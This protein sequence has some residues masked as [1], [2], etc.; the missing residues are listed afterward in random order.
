MRKNKVQYIVLSCIALSLLLLT[1]PKIGAQEKKVFLADKII[2]VVGDQMILFSDF[3]MSQEYYK[4]ENRIPSS[5]VLSEDEKT[6][7]LSQMLLVKLMATQ[8]RIDS[9]DISGIDIESQIDERQE[10]MVEQYGSMGAVEKLRGK[11]MF[12]IRDDLRK[13]IEENILADEMRNKVV[14]DVSV[15]PAE[16]QRLVK[17]L[18]EDKIPLIPVQ[19][20][21]SQILKKAPSTS[22]DKMAIKEKLLGYRE[23][24]LNGDNFAALA[25]MYS[26]D[27]GSALRGGDMG[28]QSPKSLV[29]E[30]SDAMVSLQKGQISTVVE[31]E[32]GQ[33]IIELIDKKDDKYR[34]RHILI[35]EKFTID[36]LDKAIKELDSI[37][38]VIRTGEAT[39][40]DMA[41]KYSDDDISKHNK[42]RVVNDSKELY[43]GLRSK[44]DRFYVDELKTDYNVLKDMKVGDVSS[45][46]QGYDNSG[47]VICKIIKLDRIIPEHKATIDGDYTTMVDL[48]INNRKQEVLNTWINEKVKTLYLRIEE[49]YKSYNFKDINWIK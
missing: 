4:Y 22:A 12:L 41:R 10:M 25:R 5:D 16:V 7:L 20:S 30:F 23:R 34:T 3:I 36:Q 47:N 49:P 46:F 44:T 33:H 38:N 17:K 37:A 27:E 6:E 26:D 1:V 8:A 14:S 11:P 29:P 48:V 13:Q 21:Y 45:A 31:T 2:A 43:M 40:T 15:T 18:G 9:I 28:Y 39:F 24:V 35:R 19:Y 32:Y 42:G